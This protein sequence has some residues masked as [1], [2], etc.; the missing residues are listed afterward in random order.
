MK[1]DIPPNINLAMQTFNQKGQQIYDKLLKKGKIEKDKNMGEYIVI[2]IDTQK[3]YIGEDL[4]LI[5]KQAREKMP[6]KLFYAARI[7]YPGIFS[8]AGYRER[9]YAYT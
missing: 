6:G 4:K 7:G 9:E 1:N 8:V 2:D 5:L 3:H